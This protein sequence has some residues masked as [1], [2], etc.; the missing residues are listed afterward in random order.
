MM[1]HW[2]SCPLTLNTKPVFGEIRKVVNQS[3]VWEIIPA[4]TS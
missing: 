4:I 3:R 2:E 1:N